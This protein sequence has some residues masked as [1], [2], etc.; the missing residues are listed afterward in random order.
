MR[1]EP[2]NVEQIGDEVADC[3]RTWGEDAAVVARARHIVHELLGGADPSRVMRFDL[4]HRPGQ[5]DLRVTQS[6]TIPREG[7][8]VR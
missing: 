6:E 7:A 5:V 4:S 8:A 1:P 2:S 3:L